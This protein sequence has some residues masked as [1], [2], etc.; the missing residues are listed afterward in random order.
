MN[1]S[2]FS[3]AIRPAAGPWLSRP[4]LVFRASL[5]V[6]VILTLAVLP[7]AA[8]DED[9]IAIMGITDQA[10]ALSAHGKTAQAHQKYLEAQ[11]ALT[12]FQR[13]NPGWNAPTVSFRLKYLREQVAA[14]AENAQPSASSSSAPEVKAGSVAAPSPVKLL[15][16]GAE[17]RKVLRL[18]PT[19]GDKQTMAMTLKMS[20]EMGMA[21]NK[22]PAMDIPPMLMK[23]EVEG[24]NVSAE[25][26]IA[27]QLEFTDAT[28]E[29]D[30]NSIAGVAALIKT[31]LNGIRGMT[32]TGQMN[33]QGIVKSLDMK[34]P[35]GA[36][37]QLGQTAGQINDAFA[38]SMTVL[39]DAA[40]GVGA[41]WEYKTRVK[42]QGVTTDQT[43]V[44]ELVSLEGEQFT[45][46]STITQTAANQKMDSPVMPGMKVDLNQLTGSGT[47]T[48]TQ[49][50]GQ[51]MP[52]K[53][54]LDQETQ[55]SL[56]MNVGQQKQKLDMKM[57]M[58]VTIDAK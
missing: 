37:P 58:K 52:E 11:Q 51:I 24:K 20:M 53:T 9:Y 27:Y 19:V 7:V 16:A 56:G 4:N 55:M 31:T 35:P 21:G 46:R 44:Y 36:A 42:F 57:T 43:V 13:A 39:P 34:L 49:Q 30:T 48:T 45:L 29:A 22:L 3:A 6:A 33:A 50:L 8:Q 1:L 18:H 41:K 28:V 17:P 10:D 2:R 15:E 26:E 47:A 12:T 32:G 40:I 38:S 25:G 5:F 54:S 14:T 23:L